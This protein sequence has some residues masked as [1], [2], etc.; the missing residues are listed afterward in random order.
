MLNS[1][2]GYSD[3]FEKEVC[4]YSGKPAS[5]FLQIQP[6]EWF[7]QV[8]KEGGAFIKTVKT[9]VWDYRFYFHD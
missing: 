7:D 2:L 6:K 9:K 3:E 8:R 1:G 5:A 4:L